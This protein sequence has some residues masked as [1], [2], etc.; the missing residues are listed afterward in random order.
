MKKFNI[1]RYLKRW[2]PLIALVSIFAGA[3]FMRYASNNQAYTAQ[4]VIK[5]TY[6]A[7][8]EGLTPNGEPLDVSEIFSS[9]VVKEAIERLGYSVNVDTIRSGGTVTGITPC[10]CADAAGCAGGK[11]RR[12]GGVLSDGIH[13]QA[14][15]W[16][17]PKR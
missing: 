17:Q 2:W 12:G 15:R 7:A 14:D 5:Y 1:I 3:F 11:R 6:D 4:A 10:R 8:S 13:R 16:Q 9:T